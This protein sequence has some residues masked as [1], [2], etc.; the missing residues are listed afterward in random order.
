MP[1]EPVSELDAQGA[2]DALPD[3]VLIA[4]PDAVVTHVNTTARELLGD[5]ARPG[6][7]LRE[8]MPLQDLNGCR[9][10]DTLRPYDGLTTRTG[11]VE[12]SWL[13][14]DG[15]E[16]L[17]SGRID[18]DGPHGV[19]RGVAVTLRSARARARLEKERADLITTMAHELRSPL[20]GVKG[21]TAALLDRW[22][23]FEDEQKK[24]ILE[25]VHHDTDRLARLVSELLEVAR[26]SAGRLPLA[27]SATDPVACVHAVARSVSAGTDRSVEVQV[28]GDDLQV[29]ADPDRLVQVL[30]NVLENAIR[31]G[32]GAVTV[33]VAPYDEDAVLVAVEDEGR[34]IA[35]DQRSRVFTKH[36][37]SGS[38]GGT[39]LGMYVAHGLVTAHGGSIEVRDAA[40]GGARV[41]IVWPRALD[42]H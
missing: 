8:A 30:T 21:F 32:E 3:G 23:V 13:L 35:P 10:W 16:L 25:S 27:A 6:V 15:T 34:G 28:E 41:E 36:W 29:H 31:H 22:E 20:T 42:L 18:R 33:I 2:L 14:V 19:V 37:R 11:L 38:R 24:V 9:W 5:R 17:V 1:S 39:G 40:S 7:P 4:G 26:I 12:G